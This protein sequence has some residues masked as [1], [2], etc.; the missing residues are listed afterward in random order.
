MISCACVCLYKIK[1]Q[2]F[3]TSKN[4]K[5]IQFLLFRPTPPSVGAKARLFLSSVKSLYSSY[6]HSLATSNRYTKFCNKKKLGSSDS[7]ESRPSSTFKPPTN[8]KSFSPHAFSQCFPL[9][10][11]LLFTFL[12]NNY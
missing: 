10:V 9:C 2:H 12:I 7:Q 5:K 3:S 1:F 8:D 4:K 11:Y 6:L